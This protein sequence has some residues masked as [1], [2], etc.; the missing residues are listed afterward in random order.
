MMKPIACLLLAAALL[1]AGPAMA[2]RPAKAIYR[3]VPR[4]ALIA[5]AK[6]ARVASIDNL[7]VYCDTDDTIETWLTRLTGPLVR[8]V[9]WSAGK[10]ELV[11]NLNPNDAG[12]NYCVQASLTLKH[13]KGR[14]DT[15]EIEIFFEDPKAGRPGE[16]YAFRGMMNTPDGG[17]YSRSRKEFE[18]DWRS[19][20]PHAPP[21][22]CEDPE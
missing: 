5:A 11:N 22:P 13:P 9:D 16:V 18:A 2:G 21:P 20:F 15:P 7:E 8:T 17:D 1:A 14:A 3:G 10:C 4:A 12:G 6:A 19:R